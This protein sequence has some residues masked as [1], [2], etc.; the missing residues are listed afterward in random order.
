L[1]ALSGLQKQVRLV[2]QQA[3]PAPTMHSPSR[4]IYV[5]SIKT[6]KNKTKLYMAPERDGEYVGEETTADGCG[7]AVGP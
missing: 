5:L 1:A 2:E 6:N 7:S 4:F 3:A